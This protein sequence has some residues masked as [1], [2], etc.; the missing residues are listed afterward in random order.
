M[1]T[2]STDDAYCKD[3]EASPIENKMD[4]LKDASGVSLDEPMAV[5]SSAVACEEVPVFGPFLLG[6][7]YC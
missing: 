3:P 1:T 2:I 4:N 5:V 6:T 7:G